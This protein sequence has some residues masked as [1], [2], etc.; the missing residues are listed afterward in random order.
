MKVTV[1]DTNVFIDLIHLQW[2]GQLRTLGLEIFTTEY[3]LLELHEYQRKA[4]VEMVEA[5]WI[6][7]PT[8][9][10]DKLPGYPLIGGCYLVQTSPHGIEIRPKETGNNFPILKK[11]SRSLGTNASF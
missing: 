3:V 11:S 8:N 5:K 10:R 2:L 4:L 1:T 7:D 9:E 6:N